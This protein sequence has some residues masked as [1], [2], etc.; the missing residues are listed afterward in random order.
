M[1]LHTMR[2]NTHMHI[3]AVYVGIRDSMGMSKESGEK[4]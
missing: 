4:S 1:N 2:K 3:D